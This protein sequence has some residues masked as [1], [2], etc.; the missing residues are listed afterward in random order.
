MKLLKVS[1]NV[2]KEGR[3][4]LPMESVKLE[5][6]RP[7]YD[8]LPPGLKPPR[9]GFFH[10]RPDHRLSPLPNCVKSE[11]PDNALLH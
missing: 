4:V 9:G 7:E 10:D 5:G 1:A 8:W 11:C 3:L 6:F 2:D